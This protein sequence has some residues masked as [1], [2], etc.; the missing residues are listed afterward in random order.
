MFKRIFR[1]GNRPDIFEQIAPAL[2]GEIKEAINDD[3]YKVMSEGL[4]LAG[5][6]IKGLNG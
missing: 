6:M 2:L 3:Y 4:R 5:N 1:S